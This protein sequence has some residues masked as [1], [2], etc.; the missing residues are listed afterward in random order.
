MPLPDLLPIPPFARPVYGEAI[1]PGSKSLTNRALLL[2]ALCDAPVT[3]TGA[4]FSEDTE[5][6]MS[7][8][9]ALGFDV[10]SEAGARTIAVSGQDNGFKSDSPVDLFVGLAGTAARFLTALCAAAPR[11]VYRID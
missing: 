8:L 1:L 9:T 4:L 2:A 5:L 7:A 3:L 10:K 6:M 11:G